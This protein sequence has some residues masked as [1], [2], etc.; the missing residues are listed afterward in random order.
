M[1]RFENVGMRY[2]LG[3]EVLRN[4]SFELKPGSFHFLTGPSGAGKSSLMKLLYLAHRPS[5][6]IITMF[7]QDLTM[8]SRDELPALRRRIGVVFQDFRLLDHLSAIDNVMLPL[9]IAG[10]DPKIIR[11]HAEEL[12]SWVG[13]AD[14]LEARPPTLSG[15][16][17]QRLA[18]A[19]AVIGKPDLLLADEPTGNVD[20]EMAN[21]LL[22]LFVE[23][24]KL[25]T[26]TLVATHDMGLVSRVGAPQLRLFQGE[27]V[28]LDR[29][30]AVGAGQP[31][32]GY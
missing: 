8:V 20:P 29:A 15:G 21:R 26:T 30:S 1:V 4:I 12:L 6:G 5:R 23:L 24:N 17:K 25:G 11:E 19:R 18:I 16:E 2:G 28:H 7:G 9:R 13:L 14:R 3:S 32:A 31:D 27:L 22:H 10:G